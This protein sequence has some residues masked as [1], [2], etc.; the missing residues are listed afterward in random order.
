[1]CIIARST[2]ARFVATLKGKREQQSVE[3]ALRSWFHEV[4][5]AKWK[6]AAE[7]KAAYASASI[8]DAERVVF[9]MKG[10]NYRLV[11]AVNYER[12]IVFIKWLG[13]YA[14]YDRIDVR[15]VQYGDQTYQRPSRS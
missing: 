5:R 1:M 13:S 3:A 7:V 10:N 12:Q 8:V 2:L 4:A 9:N 11:A 14:E 6:N 15:T